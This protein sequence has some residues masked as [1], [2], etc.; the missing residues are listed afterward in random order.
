M[1]LWGKTILLGVHWEFQP[2][3]PAT[4]FLVKQCGR[5]ELWHELDSSSTAV[6]TPTRGAAFLS[7]ENQ[8][9]VH[10]FKKSNAHTTTTS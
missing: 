7:L 2:C 4:N 6:S 3:F 5:D 1:F 10:F 9:M 8:N